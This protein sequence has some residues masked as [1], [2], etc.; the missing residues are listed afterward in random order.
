MVVSNNFYGA[1]ALAV[2]FPILVWSIFLERREPR[3]F[4]R[5]AA[6]AA[7]S[8]GL[9]AFWLTP[10]YVRQTMENLQWVSRPSLGWSQVAAIAVMAAFA[11]ASWMLAQ[12]RPAW[13]VFVSGSLLFFGLHV[14]GERFLGLAIMGE[15]PRHIPELD[16]AMT[17]AIVT[18]L[19]WLWKRKWLWQRMAAALLVICGLATAGRYSLRPW[20][21]YV[22]DRVYKSRVEYRMQDWVARNM[23]AARV[24]AA[25]SIRFWYDAWN[26][27]AQVDGGAAQG[28]LN[29]IT[30]PLRWELALRED[31]DK[32][33][34]WLKA[35]GAD[36]II[37]SDES[38]QDEYHDYVYPTKFSGVLPILYDDSRGNVI[39]GVP[40]RYPA[41]ARVVETARVAGFRPKTIDLDADDLREYVSILEEGPDA[42]IEM[43]WTGPDR[44]RIQARLGQGQSI[45]AQVS[46]HSRWEA[47]TARVRRDPLGFLWLHPGPGEHTI[48]VVFANRAENLICGLIT[49][50]TLAL[51]ASYVGCGLWL[52]TAAPGPA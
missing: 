10:S 29:P 28:L 20:R 46:H 45:V 47:G 41:H 43:R 2:F 26:D 24:M 37:M 16:V 1:T 22:Q 25:G 18:G 40:R 19:G 48:D 52:R 11:A 50:A 12:R 8:Y 4:G 44:F 35:V 32:S 30:V 36:A 23:P 49:C 3:I 7:L 51:L 9:T 31:P 38:S 42:P 14:L 34:L 33:A 15:P 5:A 27:L 17:L 13:T 6:I 39:H 21:L